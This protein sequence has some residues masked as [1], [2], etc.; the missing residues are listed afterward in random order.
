MNSDR[1]TVWNYWVGRVATAEGKYLRYEAARQRLE[2]AKEE[3][4]LLSQQA[5]QDQVDQQRKTLQTFKETEPEVDKLMTDD[6][7]PEQ[8]VHFPWKLVVSKGSRDPEKVFAQWTANNEKSLGYQKKATTFLALLT[9]FAIALYLL[10]Q[11]LGMGRTRDAFILVLFAC[12]LVAAGVIGLFIGFADKVMA[13]RPASADCRLPRYSDPAELAAEHYA[14]GMVLL[15][16]SWDDPGELA[17]AAKEFGC[18]AEIRPKFAEANYYFARATIAASTPQ[19]NE[20]GFVSHI[21]KGALHTVSQAEKHAIDVFLTQQDFA[22]PDLVGNYGFDTYAD[23][24]V[25]GD[26]KIVDAG[27]QATLAAIDLDT[28]NLATRFNLGVAQL[29]EGY[30]KDALETYRQAIALGKP[31][32]EPFVTDDAA[33]IGAVIGGAITDLDVVRQYCGGLNNAAYCKRFENTDLPR[34][35]SE[36]VAAAWPSA[37]GRTLAGSGVQLTDLQ[38]RGSAA[39]LGWSG[40]VENLPQGPPGKEQDALAVS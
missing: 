15:E 19:L 23:G 5:A 28:N 29:A 16:G 35:K 7:G 26:R 39:G 18:A 31:G 12:A 13:L 36:L 4:A 6:L 25:K 17:K 30:E 38:L 22:P 2:L 3:P 32:K 24:L 37:K 34:L 21:S 33:V 20:G 8:D 1:V 14:R 27:R 40:L 10:G 11:A 9:L